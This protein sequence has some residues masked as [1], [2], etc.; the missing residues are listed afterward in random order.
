MD[1]VLLEHRCVFKL[2][3]KERNGPDVIHEE[4]LALHDDDATSKYQVKIS[5]SN[6]SGADSLRKIISTVE[7]QQQQLL[8]KGAMKLQTWPC[9]STGRCP[10]LLENAMC[11]YRLLMPPSMTTR[12]RQRSVFVGFRC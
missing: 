6:L 9:T 8:W 11:L 12:V 7:E 4:M 10:Q 1:S 5:L 2:L 3:T